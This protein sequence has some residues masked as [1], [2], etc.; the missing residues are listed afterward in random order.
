MLRNNYSEVLKNFLA[1][2]ILEEVKNFQD[3]RSEGKHRAG[4]KLRNCN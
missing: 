1:E 3:D 2:K 4:A